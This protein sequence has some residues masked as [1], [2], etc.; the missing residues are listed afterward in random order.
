MGYNLNVTSSSAYGI[1]IEAHI[2]R[3]LLYM[4][5]LGPENLLYSRLVSPK[6]ASTALRMSRELHHPL[7][8]LCHSNPSQTPTVP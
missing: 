7:S 4:T 5:L 2:A 6:F 3:S 1:F 8:P